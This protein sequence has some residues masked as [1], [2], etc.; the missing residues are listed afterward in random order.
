[1]SACLVACTSLLHAAVLPTP[2]V[3]HAGD[4]QQQFINRLEGEQVV[5][6]TSS[7]EQFYGLQLEQ[8]TGTPQGGVLILHD[9]GYSPDWPFLLRQTRNYLP[10]VGWTT[11]SIDL[12]TPRERAIG[13]IPPNADT[14]TAAQ[15][16]A[17]ADWEMR[18]MERIA[19]GVANLNQAGLFNIVIVGYGDGAYWGARY[20]SERMSPEEENGYSLILVDAD[21][22]RPELATHIAELAIPTLDL[23]MN[24]SVYAHRRANERKAAAARVNHPNYQLVHDALRQ[25]F[26]GSPSIDRTTRRVWG[27]LKTNAAGQEA[28]LVEEQNF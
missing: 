15:Q 10:E 23:Y 17:E 13:I 24:D 20:L 21:L 12:P 7:V 22:T 26:Y 28:D 3:W 27:W 14:E 11:L 9:L 6:L 2:R 1:M 18:I 8:R 5:I 16:P 19:S 25:G 4:V